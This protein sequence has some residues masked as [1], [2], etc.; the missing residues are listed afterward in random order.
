MTAMLLL[1]AFMGI[2]GGYASARLYK[3]FKVVWARSGTEIKQLLC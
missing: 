3:T 1:F 2:A